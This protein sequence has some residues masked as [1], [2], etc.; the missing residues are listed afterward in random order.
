MASSPKTGMT[1]GPLRIASAISRGVA[2]FSVDETFCCPTA[3]PAA[4]GPWH[5][6]QLLVNSS[7][8]RERSACSQPDTSG[9]G[10]P[11]FGARLAT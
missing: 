4:V 6:A 1:P 3:T 10:G 5:A 9:M 2:W 8:P 11:W 7:R